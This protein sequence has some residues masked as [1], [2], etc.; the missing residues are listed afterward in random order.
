MARN[1]YKPSRTSIGFKS[2]GQG[3]QRSRY[4]FERQQ[5]INIDALKLAKEQHKEA[6]NIHIK[7]LSDKARFEEGVIKEK[8]TLENA[9][10]NR[11]YDALSIKADR[12]V[13]R[14]EGEAKELEKYAD[15][16]KDLAPKLAKTAY[17]LGSGATKAAQYF[18]G[19]KLISEATENNLYSEPIKEFDKAN[20]KIL[21]QNLQIIEDKDIPFEERLWL[22]DKTGGS[23]NERYGINSFNE[24]KANT[25]EQKLPSI[26]A[27][28]AGIKLTI[29]N[30]DEIYEFTAFERLRQLGIRP[31]SKYGQKIIQQYK[32]W[33]RLHK[34]GLIDQRDV[35]ST[36][37]ALFLRNNT[38]YGLKGSTDENDN[39]RLNIEFNLGVADVELGT[40]SDGKGNV[41]RGISNKGVAFELYGKSLVQHESS[42]FNSE[43]DIRRFFETLCVSGSTKKYS[44]EGD[45]CVTWGKQHPVR[46][47]R[48]IDAWTN[49]INDKNNRN[50]AVQQA[51]EQKLTTEINAIIQD[52]DSAEKPGVDGG[53]PTNPFAQGTKFRNR[54]NT[55]LIKKIENA[56]ISDTAK[57]RLL[58]RASLLSVSASEHADLYLYVMEPLTRLS[59]DEPLIGQTYDE[60]IILATHRFNSLSI[61][62]RDALRPDVEF[63]KIAQNFTF[64]KGSTVFRGF[65]GIYVRANDRLRTA[66][67]EPTTGSAGR[68]LSI[69]GNR[70]ASHYAARVIQVAN[71]LKN[72]GHKDYQ[73]NDLA[74]IDAAF[75]IVE[76][77][78]KD[79]DVN[80]S[81]EVSS[82]ASDIAKYNRSIFKR[83]TSAFGPA[84][85]DLPHLEYTNFTNV[86]DQVKVNRLELALKLS[87]TNDLSEISNELRNEDINIF[88]SDTIVN[89]I[90]LGFVEPESI[91]KD[92]RLAGVNKAKSAA[93]LVKLKNIHTV[94]PYFSDDPNFLSFDAQKLDTGKFTTEDY[95]FKLKLKEVLGDQ[96]FTNL[97]AYSKVTKQSLRSVLNKWLKHHIGE[98]APQL[99]G[100]S[101]TLAELQNDNNYVLPMNIPGTTFVNLAKNEGGFVPMTTIN[102]YAQEYNF[103]IEEAFKKAKGID[104][105]KQSGVRG[106]VFS[107][108]EK[109]IRNGGINQLL[110]EGMQPE[111]LKVFGFLDYDVD[112]GDL[113]GITLPMTNKE[114]R[115]MLKQKRKEEL[116]LLSGSESEYMHQ[117]V[118]GA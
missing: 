24:I 28:E 45:S 56:D 79:G 40:F 14:L 50:I 26:L 105:Q 17:T 114:Y 117:R 59:I 51:N 81:P 49:D 99:M 5:Q 111:L 77:E 30:T 90:K 116:R 60:A 20:L 22:K 95:Q 91:L 103:D 97:E 15:Y 92:V 42:R 35:S 78:Y 94:D 39:E 13:D 48:I 55:L 21:K 41:T 104:Y 65:Q 47:E 4:E 101:Q 107:D 75:A 33:G 31:D 16:W 96:A 10:R 2:I 1:K 62:E 38:V 61:K 34:Q 86:N 85:S 76:E 25:A 67:G 29:G 112:P 88:S 87:E 43:K 110:R 46:V 70:A 115:K 18:K 36:E 68:T 6:T 102:R 63:A 83:T 71:D 9:V 74:A 106:F 53:D 64:T 118:G 66:E 72:S 52:Y 93:E 44:A 109:F 57:T 82:N 54:L 80:N 89:G 37:N 98:D 69:S 8:Q 11:T 32:S 108:T 12:D 113:K 58:T 27:Q 100:D 19:Q 7:G 23:T 73:N 84:G 3:L